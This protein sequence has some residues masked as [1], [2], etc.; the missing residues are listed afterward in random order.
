MWYSC[1][2]TSNGVPCVGMGGAPY[3]PIP[4]RASRM[5]PSTGAAKL[6]HYMACMKYALTQKMIVLIDFHLNI[7]IIKVRVINYSIHTS[8]GLLAVDKQWCTDSAQAFTSI[9]AFPKTK[10]AGRVDVLQVVEKRIWILLTKKAIC[11]N[12][13]H[14][15]KSWT[16]LL[17]PDIN[18][19]IKH[20]SMALKL[21]KIIF[22]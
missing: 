19:K 7:T 12:S 5:A 21:K 6:G 4:C 9:E 14:Q 22:E 15:R 13:M 17:K 16:K 18:G 1:C 2:L 10:K 11:I 3:Q 20:K 8:I